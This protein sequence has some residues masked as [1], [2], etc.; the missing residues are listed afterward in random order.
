[1]FAASMMTAIADSHIKYS[2]KEV[3]NIINQ[4]KEEDEKIY[5]RK[6]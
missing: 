6:D 1:M 2:D 4:M 5:G 3:E